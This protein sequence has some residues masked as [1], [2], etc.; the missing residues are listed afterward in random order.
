MKNAEDLVEIEMIARCAQLSWVQGLSQQAIAA[1]LKIS[2]SK[3][4]RL[5]VKARQFIS[6][7][8]EMPEYLHLQ[9]EIQ[10]CFDES[11]N[12]RFIIVPTGI[13][14]LI[15]SNL[16]SAAALY[17]EEMLK[18]W[19]EKQITVGLACGRT[20]Q[21]AIRFLRV[22]DID[23]LEKILVYPLSIADDYRIVNHYPNTL[24]HELTAKFFDHP[25]SPEVEGFNL[26][27]F[28][29]EREQ[30]ILR[31]P[32]DSP[33][34]KNELR[35]EILARYHLADIFH[36]VQ[37][38]DLFMVGI[39]SARCPSPNFDEIRNRHPIDFDKEKAVGEINFQV[40]G[41]PDSLWTCDDLFAVSL[42]DL[43]EACANGKQVIAIA[44]GEEKVEP[45]IAALKW[46]KKLKKPFFNTLITTS[47]VG[48]EIYKTFRED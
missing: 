33:D 48:K 11:L 25:L 5:L 36:Q 30:E 19:P 10:K 28:L 8:L 38:A 6:L 4:S 35:K 21:S 13:D 44:G 17:I 26:H 32:Y 42:L 34:E 23:S 12:L 41:E 16:G 47:E 2:Q 14:N 18:S 9:E 31:S 1:E 46:A 39:G 45:I 3:V 15:V 20:L 43:Q 29:S 37:N 27:I 22:E 7:R 40:F 24:V